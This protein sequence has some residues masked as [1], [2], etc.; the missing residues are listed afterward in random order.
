M[1]EWEWSKKD[2]AKKSE[3]SVAMAIAPRQA[4][5]PI[6]YSSE[7]ELV[8][9]I[10]GSDTLQYLSKT[11][12]SNFSLTSKTLCNIH[13]KS[14]RKLSLKRTALMGVVNSIIDEQL[15]ILFTR[16]PNTTH[17]NLEECTDITDVSL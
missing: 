17:L 13:N 4:P 16:Y 12:R 8:L 9:R 1:C 2:T 11:E 6:A 5:E 3:K 7:G 15:K 10:L 14:I